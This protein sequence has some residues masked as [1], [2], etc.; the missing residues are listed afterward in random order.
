MKLKKDR[1]KINKREEM[2]K[3]EVE[4]KVKKMLFM[5]IVAFF[6]I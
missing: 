3:R 6:S 4:L 2:E 1:I 5:V